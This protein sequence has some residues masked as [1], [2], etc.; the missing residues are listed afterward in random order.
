MIADIQTNPLLKLERQLRWLLPPDL[1]AAVWV[2]PSP[3]MLMKVFEHLRTLQHVLIDYVPRDVYDN[4]PHPGHPRYSWQEGALLFTDLA[5]FTP[6]LEACASEGLVGAELLLKV[7]NNY[8]SEMIEIL[9]KSSGNLLEF[10]GDALLVQFATGEPQRDIT[11]AINTGL[12]MQRAMKPFQKIATYRGELSLNMRV[13]IHAGQYVTADIGTPQR[14]AH[15]LLGRAVTV[16]KKAEGCGQIRQVSL[17]TCVKEKLSDRIQL[18]P[19]DNHH[20]LVVDNLSS[21]ELGEYEITVARRRST[22]MFFDRSTDGLLNEIEMAVQRVEPL[23]SY[24]PRSVLQLMV[25]TASDRR[26]PPAFPTIAIAFVNLMGL[27]ESVDD[28]LPEETAD[29]V[30]CFSNAFSLIN[31]V[32]EVKGGILQKVTYH[33]IGS[34]ILIHFG[35][36]N[37]DANDSKRAIE[38]MSAIRDLVQSI[39]PPTV[40]GQPI[41]LTC[42]IGLTY[43]PV[44]AAEIGERRGRREFNVLGDTV[45]TAARIMSRAGENEI[46]MNQ[47]MHDRISSEFET[48]PLGEFCLK[49]K[50]LPQPI[51]ALKN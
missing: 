51:F 6:L 48:Y 8:F 5:G 4:P 44:F 17:T 3:P 22:Y 1:Y 45:N 34:E 25:E 50:S 24:M 49:G 27:P 26:I 33:S 30:N 9:S 13:G 41:Q 19:I 32:V 7:L 28:A 23:T 36:L 38:T 21:E 2:D 46:W 31:G 37:P 39:A 43:G 14:M 47:A 15:V 20:W 11:Q 16:A 35:V 29:L 12:R 40:Q 10:T 18:T 42:R